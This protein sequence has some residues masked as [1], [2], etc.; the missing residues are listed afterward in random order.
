MKAQN[1]WN[2]FETEIEPNLGNR[3]KTTRKMFEYL[4]GIEE[5]L[6]IVETG[7]MRKHDLVGD[8]SST[9]IFDRYLRERDGDLFSVDLNPDAVAFFSY[10]LSSKAQPFFVKQGFTVLGQQ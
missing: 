1:F 10:L 6:L 4:D 3:A 7:C 5:P 2:W 9:M 8:G